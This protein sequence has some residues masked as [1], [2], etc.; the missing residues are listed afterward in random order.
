MAD[1][2]GV[3]T[4]A[5]TTA[6]ERF[7]APEAAACLYVGEVMHARL[8]PVAHRFTYRVFNLLVD[9]DRLTDVDRQSRLFSVGRFNLFSFHQA[10]HGSGAKDGLRAFIASLLENAGVE[11]GAAKR[12]LLWCYPRVLGFV[13]NPIAIF[14]CY[15][16]AGG[17]RAVIYEVRNTFGDKHMYVAPVRDGELDEAG[18]RQTQTKL[19]F[20]SPFLDMPMTYRFR[21]HPPTDRLLIRILETDPAGPILSATFRGVRLSLRSPRLLALFFSLP[22]LTL[23]VVGAIHFEALRLFMKG[24]RLRRRPGAPAPVSLDG[25]PTLVPGLTKVGAST[26]DNGIGARSNAARGDGT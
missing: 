7:V 11:P 26:F 14:F 1:R 5:S 19:L 13:F 24:L 2:G 16:A 18:L 10:D 12:V 15:D 6:A 4:G 8:K 17:L 9:L 23:K 3:I 20:V 22:L 21:I 25:R